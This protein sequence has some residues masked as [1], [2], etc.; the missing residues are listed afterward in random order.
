MRR[1]MAARLPKGSAP[2]AAGVSMPIE[3]EA[4]E[5]A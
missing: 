4:F 3:E 5:V 1:S 2:E